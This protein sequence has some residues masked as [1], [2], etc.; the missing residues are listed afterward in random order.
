[1]HTY[2]QLFAVPQFRTLFVAQCLTMAA[3]ATAGLALGTITFAET[4]SALLT[5]LSMFGGPLVGVLSSTFLLSASD[6]LR[7]RTA[8]VVVATAVGVIDLLQAVP[9]LPVPGRFALLA[10]MWVVLSASAGAAIGL[11]SELLPDAAFVLGRST[12]NIAVGTMQVAGYGFGGVL[13]LVL[14]P[15]GLFLVAGLC[16]LLAAIL[17][18]TGLADHP[19]R[20]SGP[21]VRR[22]M[23]V[24]RAL[25]GSGVLRPIY[26]SSWVPNGLVVGCEALFIPYAGERAGYLLAASAA[27]MLAG[28]VVVGRFVPPA[29][30]D[31]LLEPLRL[32][33]AAPFL[34]FWWGPPIPVAMVLVFVAAF[35]FAASLPLQER[36]VAHTA[37]E[38][39]GQA[40][41]L[42]G[43][44]L[45]AGQAVG[46]AFAGVVADALGS[47]PGGTGRTMALMGALS[48]L[49]TLALVPGLRR[50][51]PLLQQA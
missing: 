40:L 9:G 28:D 50:S 31:R 15:T 49:V 22:T 45:G 12:L 39:R 8:L 37:P 13:L 18:R 47:V 10:L 16:S 21:L 32:L 14:S 1:M 33:L 36:M 30:R 38:V 26:L 25:L 46:A 11:M 44:G 20:A 5:G 4:G 35:G 2:R 42:R 7:P 29:T 17:L 41:G 34:L 19:P 23:R 43:T 3:G 6:T 27:G 48:L 24:N 51:A